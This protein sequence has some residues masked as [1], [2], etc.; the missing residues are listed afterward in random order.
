LCKD[1]PAFAIAV[2]IAIASLSLRTT[3]SRSRDLQDSVAATGSCRLI[4]NTPPT[5]QACMRFSEWDFSKHA[6]FYS[7]SHWRLHISTESLWRW[8]SHSRLHWRLHSSL[9]AWALLGE[10]TGEAA[11]N[12]HHL[13]AECLFAEAHTGLVRRRSAG[14]E[15][16]ST[17]DCTRAKA[18]SAL[19]RLC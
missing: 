1:K 10:G 11:K 7:Y 16:T 3:A 8:H 13:H 12:M 9:F 14:D 6:G 18:P 4:A 17:R 15:A 2:V 5:N 19:A